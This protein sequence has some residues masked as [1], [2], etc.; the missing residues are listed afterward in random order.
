[1]FTFNLSYSYSQDKG[2]YDIDEIKS[3]Y[4]ITLNYFVLFEL[5]Y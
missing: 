1:M 2:I 4:L 3:S 5:V